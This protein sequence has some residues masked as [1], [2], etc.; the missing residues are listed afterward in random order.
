MSKLIC[1]AKNGQ[2]LADP[3]NLSTHS[4]IRNKLYILKLAF[5]SM[6]FQKLNVF[7]CRPSASDR[8][9]ITSRNYFLKIRVNIICWWFLLLSFWG[10]FDEE[11][12]NRFM[13][14]PRRRN[15]LCISWEIFCE[16]ESLCQQRQGSDLAPQGADS[17]TPPASLKKDN[18]SLNI[19]MSRQKICGNFFLI[20]FLFKL[21][22]V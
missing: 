13:H 9:N 15:I 4:W 22:F 18:S 17:A 5:P 21:F 7:F 11:V 12:R 16:D 6:F 3:E 10:R 2:T 8:K 19:S 1:F 20:L 14:F